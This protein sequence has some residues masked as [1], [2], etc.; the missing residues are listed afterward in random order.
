MPTY[1]GVDFHARQQ[2]VAWCDTNDGE[3]QFLKLDHSEPEKVREFYTSFPNGVIVGLEACGYSQWFE[4]L[5]FELQIETRIGNATEI[6]RQ[7]RSL[8]KTD[9]LRRIPAE[10]CQSVGRPICPLGIQRLSK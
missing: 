3:I 10:S 1:C 2:D 4:D 7:A 8:Q 5:L 6:R 9:R